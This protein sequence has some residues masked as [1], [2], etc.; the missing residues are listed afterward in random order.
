MMNS[1]VRFYPAKGVIMR[2]YSPRARPTL[3]EGMAIDTDRQD[4]GSPF[5]TKS[6]YLKKDFLI[7][8]G[9]NNPSPQKGQKP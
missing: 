3:G 1:L 2:V 6:V 7:L 5:E 4:L 8:M 9:V